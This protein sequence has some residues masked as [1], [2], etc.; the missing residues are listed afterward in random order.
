M[1]PSKP[2]L[3]VLMLGLVSAGHGHAGDMDP[4]AEYQRRV[5]ERYVG[6]FLSLDLDGDGSVSRAEARSDLNFGP[7]FD[8]MDI[9]RDGIVTTAELQRF[10]EAEYGMRLE[11]GKR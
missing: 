11:V 7:R 4:Q 3:G 10:I 5:A 1:S 9:N 8:D 6:L 2:L